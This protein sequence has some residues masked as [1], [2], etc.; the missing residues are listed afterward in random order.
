MSSNQSVHLPELSSVQRS[1]QT[2][3][4]AAIDFWN[5]V[6]SLKASCPL[7]QNL[8]LDYMEHRSTTSLDTRPQIEVL[9]CKY[10]RLILDTKKNESEHYKFGTQKQRLSGVH[11][12]LHEKFPSSATLNKETPEGAWYKRLF[13][14]FQRESNR[15]AWQSGQTVGSDQKG[16]RSAEMFD[17]VSDL[18]ANGSSAGVDLITMGL[19]LYNFC[20]RAGELGLLSMTNTKWKH[21][22]LFFVL[23]N[24]KNAREQT[25]DIY[26]HYHTP[27]LC[28]FYW[29]ATYMI[30]NP[31]SFATNNDKG[32]LFP[33]FRH[34]Y[35]DENDPKNPSAVAKKV[36]AQLD[37]L[38]S[39]EEG[40]SYKSQMFRHG[41]S[42]DMIM[43][44]ASRDHCSV[45]LGAIYRG[46]WNFAGEC[47]LF[48]YLF[49]ELYTTESGKA[50][51]GY[52]NARMDVAMPSLNPIYELYGDDDDKSKS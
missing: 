33:R 46:G 32:W 8:T 17:L 44:Q 10:S 52:P 35:G 4:N 13:I 30:V 37:R 12:Y 21:G 23:P 48:N 39:N 11:T 51:A 50:L 25:L 3:R 28:P 47:E 2:N 15:I 5:S 42:D 9:F 16:I 29:M 20:G 24:P 6:F 49:K 7:L 38:L 36:T 34:F 27:L 41:S 26:P 43:N 45:M 31:S 18:A 14:S 40:D 22:S 19:M 1:T